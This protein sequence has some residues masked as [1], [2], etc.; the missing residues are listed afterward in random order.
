MGSMGDIYMITRKVVGTVFQ[1]I[2]LKVTLA[3]M[4][5]CGVA[6]LGIIATTIILFS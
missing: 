1:D 5:L 4:I 3:G 2:R 6:V